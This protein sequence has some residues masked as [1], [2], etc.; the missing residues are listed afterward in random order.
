MQSAVDGLQ[1]P[2]VVRQ[3]L[4]RYIQDRVNNSHN[5][6]ANVRKSAVA[7]FAYCSRLIN[8]IRTIIQVR[9]FEMPN[10]LYAF[11]NL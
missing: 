8:E 3:L 1:N 6:I 2:D 10:F 9:I 7:P 11:L 4:Q 5:D